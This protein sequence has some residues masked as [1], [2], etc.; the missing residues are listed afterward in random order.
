ME[1]L[2]Q[3]V[4][5]DLSLR[6]DLM[7]DV[8]N[9]EELLQLIASLVQEL[10]DSDFE[11]LLRLLYRLDVAEVKVKNAVDGTNPDLATDV[12]AKLILEREK[13]KSISRAFFRKQQNH[14][15]E[16]PDWIF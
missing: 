11:G 1:E 6:S 3:L 10:I 13:E 4:E 8:S 15:P 16:D 9:E 7:E 2:K 14:T 12:I 5:K